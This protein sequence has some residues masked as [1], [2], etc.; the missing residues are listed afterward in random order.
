MVKP[1]IIQQLLD[2]LAKDPEH[3]KIT[4]ELQG[5]PTKSTTPASLLAHYTLGEDG[6]LQYDQTRLCIPKGPL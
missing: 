6:L 2:S 1:Q 4:Q 5:I 3:Q